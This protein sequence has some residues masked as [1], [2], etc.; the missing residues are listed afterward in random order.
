M[1]QNQNYSISFVLKRDKMKYGKAAIACRITVNGRRV[2]ISTKKSID[3]IKWSTETGRAKGNSEES[4]LIN[5][6]IDIISNEIMRHHN[7][8]LM[9]GKPIDA[10]ALK[11]NYLGVNEKNTL[12]S[13]AS[14]ITIPECDH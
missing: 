2:E 7:N 14:I 8:M 5:Q 6:A 13:R 11:N 1:K 10:Q 3:P 4:R 12:Y 9:N